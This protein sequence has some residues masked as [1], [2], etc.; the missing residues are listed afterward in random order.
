LPLFRG[1]RGQ[2]AADRRHRKVLVAGGES[3]G[4]ADARSLIG[5]SDIVRAGIDA[6]VKETGAD[7]LIVVSDVYDHSTRLRSFERIANAAGIASV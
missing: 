3:T 6:L 1:A 5:S 7:A 2:P 4:D